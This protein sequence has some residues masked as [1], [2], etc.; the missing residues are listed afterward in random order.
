MEMPADLISKLDFSHGKKF[1]EE[2]WVRHC[3]SVHHPSSSPD[4]SFFLLV[5]FRCYTIHLSEDSV[6]WMLQSC[7]GGSAV[8]FH[9]LFQSDRHFCFSVSSKAVDFMIYNLKHFIGSCFDVYFFLWNNGAHHW[10][11]E[12]FLWEQEQLREWNYVQSR[13]Q[14]KVEEPKTTELPIPA[15]FISPLSWFLIHPQESISQA[16]II[17]PFEWESS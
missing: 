11:R 13:K 5:V 2:V 6:A 9:V 10:E 8:G 15:E 3:K 14:K 17:H 7:L 4:G 1:Q 16:I 12:K